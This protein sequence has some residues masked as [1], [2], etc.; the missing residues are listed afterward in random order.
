MTVRSRQGVGKIHRVMRGK[1]R[2]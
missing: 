1:I 2:V